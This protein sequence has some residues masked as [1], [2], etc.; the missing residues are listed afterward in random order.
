MNPDYAAR[1]EPAATVLAP[2]TP[3]MWR[4][5]ASAGVVVT[6]GVQVSGDDHPPDTGMSVARVLAVTQRPSD[7]SPA[8]EFTVYARTQRADPVSAWR[9]TQLE[10]KT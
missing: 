5:W 6:A 4:Q 10:L 8:I 2:I 3:E 1:A 7:T 9:I